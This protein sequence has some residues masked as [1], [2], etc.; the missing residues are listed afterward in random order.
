[1]LVLSFVEGLAVVEAKKTSVDVRL[2]EAQLTHYVTEI[3]KRQSF[4]PFG[5]LANGLYDVPALVGFG[6]DAVE[7]WFTEK[8]V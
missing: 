2:A 1:V 8:E 3:E 7:G 6:Q 4:H 5:F